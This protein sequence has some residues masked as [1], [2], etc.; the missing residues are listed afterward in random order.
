MMR[1]LMTIAAIS[2]WALSTTP[3]HAD[4]PT[5][6]GDNARAGATS[7]SLSMPLALTWVVYSPAP[8]RPAWE[9]PR[10]E[11]IEGQRMQH[12][13]TFDDALHVV[14]V[15]NRVYFGS[16]VD[17]AVHC[18]DAA[19]G[20]PCWTFFTEGP[21]RLAPTV[22][23]GKVYVG[24]DDGH[25]YCLTATAGSLLWKYRAGPADERLLARG[26]MISRW[27]VRTG[28]LVD[29]GVAYFGAGIFPHESVY[30]CAADADDG[31]AVWRNDSISQSNAG[32]DDLSPQ[33]YLLATKDRL[34][35]PSGRTQPAVFD[36]NTG[37][38]IYKPAHSRWSTAGVVGGAKA[39]LV[40]DQIYVSGQKYFLAMNQQNG[41][42]G[43]AWFYGRQM[44]T[45][46]EKAFIATGSAVVAVDRAAHARASI[47]LHK[48]VLQR[49]DLRRKVPDP[50][51][52]KKQAAVLEA[53]IAEHAA[54]GV[55]WKTPCSHQSSLIVTGGAVLV[56]GEDRVVAF[57]VGSGK[58]L[59]TADVEGT[60]R[61]LAVAGGRL[62]VSTDQGKIYA[63]ASSGDA[64]PAPAAATHHKAVKES[65]PYPVDDKTPLYE[66]AAKSIIE[67][68]GV[69]R[70]FCL[71]VG[72][73][74]GRLAYELAKRT[75]LK[76][77]GVE[78]DAEKAA[79]SRVSLSK[80]GLYGHRVTIFHGTIEDA[81]LP[82]FFANLVV[83]D[84]TLSTGSLPVD[85]KP[86]GRLV[87]PCGG[88]VY[89]P[90]TA[91]A[92]SDVPP[93][94]R[95]N[96]LAAF[97]RMLPGEKPEIGF[98]GG[99]LLLKR[100]S[101]DGAGNWTHQYAEPGNTAC[102]D[103]L[104]VKGGMRVLWYGDPGPNQIINRHE[105]AAAPLCLDGRMF[106]QGID[107]VRAYDA[108]NGLFLWE[109]KD[110][111]AIR[112]GIFA[113]YESGNLAAGDGSLFVAAGATC[114]QLDPATG[115]VVRVHVIPD[116][117]DDLPRAWGYV[118]YDDGLLIGTNT[119]RKE[120]APQRRGRGRVAENSTDTIFAV[121]VESG[122]HLWA[123]R[124]K[125]IQHP[126]ISV[127]DGRV[128]F[129]DST[130]TPEAREALLRKDKTRLKQLTGE[131]AR[132]AEAEM[133]RRDVRL[134][135]ALDAHTG[136]KL[137]ARPVDVT[138]CSKIGIGGGLLTAMYKDG[139][140][141]LCGANAN[142][143][144]WK[145]FLSGEFSQ[146]R[147]VVLDTRSGKKLW[148]LDAN[149]RHRP[150]IV[151]KRIIAEPW[152]FDLDT[153]KQL[154]REHPLTGEQTVWQ[155]SRPG[156]HCGGLSAAPNT[157]LFRSGF[158]AY[159]DLLED[160]GTCHFSGHR[161][162]CWINA[163]AAGGLVIIPEAS[164]GCVCPFSI[165]STVVLQPQQARQG[166]GIYSAAGAKT[167]VK[168]L[169]VNLGGAGDRRDGSGRLWL[170]CPR[171]RNAGRLEF[172]LDVTPKVAADGG[173]YRTDPR[174]IEIEGT[175]APWLFA[176]G[177]RGMERCS[178]PLL[179]EGQ[180]PASYTAV[181]YFVAAAGTAG[182]SSTVD[183]RLQGTTVASGLDVLKEAGG[184]GRPLVRR[185]KGIDVERDLVVEVLPAGSE[186]A[187]ASQPVLA[188]IEVIRE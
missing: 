118:A 32:R 34:F 162:G 65:Q 81:P 37:K 112:K 135:V 9:G 33:G 72:S 41:A 92:G 13:I 116:V 170:A 124:G 26:E 56:G 108:Y 103:D 16:S 68:T 15:G 173:Y 19:T 87:K 121:D 186:Q 132:Q 188:G 155:F 77:Y 1:P 113:N 126:T 182:A 104:R 140:L 144:Y 98:R 21:V 27:P 53:Q 164:A 109:Y 31:T 79:A 30:L 176:T 159:Y 138:D 48:L 106:I 70:G 134:A 172:M 10:S 88:I 45:Q 47:A 145:Q 168:H 167:P 82:D 55:L 52:Y 179:S 2:A 122:K 35:V 95:E 100:G 85:V 86:I 64:A 36:K 29:D 61:G 23:D 39:L 128:F 20:E 152:A 99:W 161:S 43:K 174:W 115:K 150:I 7:E 46:G 156:H 166:W 165:T 71:V 93:D 54:T 123:Y 24:S 51:E 114:M 12:R 74:K 177:I 142:G 157:L 111:G 139:R 133:K 66:R 141:V 160:S 146:R 130:L 185:F 42:Y 96:A 67:Q 91:A 183:I 97:S 73:E 120:L 80:A 6:L 75:E 149:Y 180:K 28:V 163:I 158:T 178:L 8:P 154:T 25:V 127:G 17:H 38:L 62:F 4:W 184:T 58:Q 107:S 143:H 11:P 147:L 50:E 117:D 57:D 110:P 101:L 125:T 153:G 49:T 137:W 148:A 22:V 151:G 83:S 181:L 175:D 78:S 94:V 136:A 119:I 14:A 171:P 44:A 60:A 102:S 40:D 105:A 18:A 76:I 131:A 3:G 187:A 69:T 129:I 59:W 89:L 84:A 90:W 63:F 5:Y 169:A